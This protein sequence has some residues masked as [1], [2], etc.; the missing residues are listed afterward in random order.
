MFEVDC[1]AARK[2]SRWYEFHDGAVGRRVGEA[3]RALADR[4]LILHRSARLAGLFQPC[5]SW[6]P[7]ALSREMALLV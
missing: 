4:S 3:S 2:A 7:V 5:G 6:P 1:Y